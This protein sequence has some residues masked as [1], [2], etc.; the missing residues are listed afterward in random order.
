MLERCPTCG[1]TI[2]T[3]MESHPDKPGVIEILS[4]ET[5]DAYRIAVTIALCVIVALAIVA[6]EVLFR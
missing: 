6:T 3:L 4:G 5:G 2:G 1:K